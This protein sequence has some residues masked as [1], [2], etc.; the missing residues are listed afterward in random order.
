MD[1]EL[2]NKY[3][4]SVWKPST[5]GFGE[6]GFD[7]AKEIADDEW[8]L[9]VGC[10]YHPYKDLVKNIVGIDPA[11]DA[12]DHKVRIED[13]ET[14][15]RFDVAFCLGSLNFGDRA[16][17]INQI[18]KVVSFLKPKSRIYWR[19]NPG[20]YDHGNQMQYEIDFYPWRDNDHYTMAP[21]WGYTAT[22]VKRDSGYNNRIFAVW[23]KE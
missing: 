1:Q 10:G 5:S 16:T 20:N 2:L 19:C 22:T 15:Q 17:I 12:A 23:R 8:V 3:F 9:D 6:S 4:A 21:Q 11:N 18:N 14:D 13:F 7:L